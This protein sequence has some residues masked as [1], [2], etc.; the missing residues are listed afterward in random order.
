MEDGSG[1]DASKF[2]GIIKDKIGPMNFFETTSNESMKLDIDALLEWSASQLDGEHLRQAFISAQISS[3]ELKKQ[4][5]YRIVKIAAKTTA[6]TAGLNPVPISDALLIA[7]QQLIMCVKITNIFWLN[8]GSALNL[9]E[10]LKA[11]LLQ[12][13]GKATAAS[14]TKFIPVL[15]QLINAAVA[16]GLT[17]GF[18]VAIVEA[19]AMALNEFLKTGK[20]PVWAEVFNSKFIFK[21]MNIAKDQFK[22]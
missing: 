3:I 18:G 9:E 16:G 13:V 5:A 22:G 10:L 4:E 12:I 19:N 17:Y 8:T 20:I 15:G 11:Q 6:A 7:P 14:L 21:I 2:K 1:K